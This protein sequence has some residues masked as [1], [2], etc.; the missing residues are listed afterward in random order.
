MKWASRFVF[1]LC[2]IGSAMSLWACEE[3]VDE[4]DASFDCAA[5]CERY[6]DCFDSDYDAQLCTQECK[7]KADNDEEFQNKADNCEVCIDNRSCT[8]SFGCV[9][10]CIGIVP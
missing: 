5:I 6:R 9:D 3:T 10:E 7:G 1:A 8:E 4:L 2:A